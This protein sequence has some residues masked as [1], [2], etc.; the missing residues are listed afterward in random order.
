MG[1]IS[2]LNKGINAMIDEVRT[3][4]SFKIGE[5]FED[6]VRQFLFINDDYDILERTHNYNSNSKDYVESSLK[7]DFKF[8]DRRTKKEFYVEAK[9]RTSDYKGKIVWCN[10]KQLFRYREYHKEKPVFLI[11]GMG[12]NPN[13]PEFL[14]L[15]SLSQAKYTGLFISVV[16]KFEIEFDKPVAS[17]TLW[18][19]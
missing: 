11:L 5:R 7:P 6:Y 1:L 13:Y 15:I 2:I 8:R 10:E 12:E 18:G 17:K 14:S 4:E 3:P 19:R 16:E 9:F